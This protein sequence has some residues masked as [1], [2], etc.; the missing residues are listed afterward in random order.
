MFSRTRPNTDVSA[1]QEQVG[2]VKGC[3]DSSGV[4]GIGCDA[5]ETRRVTSVDV[6]AV[7]VPG[8]HQD[9]VTRALP[10]VVVTLMPDGRPQAS[11]VWVAY[12]DG[13]ISLNSEAG[14]QK[15]RNMRTD[16][17]VTLLIVDPDD[18]HRYLELRCDVVGFRSEGALEHRAELD[19]QYLGADHWTDPAGDRGE[20]IIVDLT[21]VAVNAYG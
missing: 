5:C 3:V 2:G 12:D 11:V 21:P 7:A 8:S 6:P 15:V 16:P 17:R 18:Q 10:A 20:R 13:C 4:G 1:D 14:R 9:L 19:R